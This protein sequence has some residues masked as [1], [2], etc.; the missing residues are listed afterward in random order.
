MDD[1][2]TGPRLDADEQAIEDALDEFASVADARTLITKLR[3]TA[4]A[5]SESLSIALDPETLA[6]LRRR[7]DAAGVELG[8]WIKRALAEYREPVE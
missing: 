5:Q 6:T 2:K 8:E 1:P 7:A 3:L 4:K